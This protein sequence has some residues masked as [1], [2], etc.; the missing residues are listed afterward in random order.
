MSAR[1]TTRAPSS[2][3]AAMLLRARHAAAVRAAVAVGLLAAAALLTT[4][5]RRARDQGR[6]A[7]LAADRVGF[8]GPVIRSRR[9]E[10]RLPVLT[11]PP[12]VAEWMY[13]HGDESGDQDGALGTDSSWVSCLSLLS[14][15]SPAPNPSPRR[16]RAR[17]YTH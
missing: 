2:A 17:A 7:L 11:V 8:F 16:A 5:G 12:D 4:S 13:A 6:S 15:F 14:C 3:E 9:G 1:R 10:A